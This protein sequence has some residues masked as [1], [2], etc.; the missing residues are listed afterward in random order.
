MIKA[1]FQNI[2]SAFFKDVAKMSLLL[3]F[4]LLLLLHLLPDLL[5]HLD[6]I[7]T[8]SSPV[9]LLTPFVTVASLKN[10]I[11]FQDLHLG[12]FTLPSYTLHICCFRGLLRHCD[13]T[14]KYY[15]LCHCH[16][17][18]WWV[19]PQ[20]CFVWISFLLSGFV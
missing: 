10:Y 6:A 4:S 17:H 15:L 13:R 7:V 11:M 20:R 12:A 1:H 9:C 19:Q 18:G 16:C 5:L 2:Y 3:L 14:S 8:M